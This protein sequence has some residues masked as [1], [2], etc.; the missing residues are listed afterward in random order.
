MSVLDVGQ[1]LEWVVPVVI[2]KCI[3][4]LHSVIPAK[5]HVYMI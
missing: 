5:L 3:L 4:L 2:F 1:G